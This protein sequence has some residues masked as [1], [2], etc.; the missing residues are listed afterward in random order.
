[1]VILRRNPINVVSSWVV[2]NM[3]TEHT[4]GEHPLVR[5]RYLRP[6]GLT[7]PNGQSSSVSVAAWNVGLLT[8]ALRDAAERH[9]DWIVA[10]HDDLCVD[11]VPRFKSL[12]QRIGLHWT[13]AMED[14]LRKTDDPAFAVHHGTPRTH[15]NAVTA[16]TAA[17]RRAEQATQY[18]RRLSR[19]QVTE[20]Q[21]VLNGFDLGDWGAPED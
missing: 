20:A 3:W 17:S 15:P 6:L 10:S 5:E 18:R 12:A 1:V 7:P 2:L 9:P 11:P 21:S 8:R 19:E 16:T 13:P 4:I 14:Y